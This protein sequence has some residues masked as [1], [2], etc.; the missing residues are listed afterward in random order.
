MK[1]M[2]SVILAFIFTFM[3]GGVSFGGKILEP[4][5]PPSKPPADVTGAYVKGYFTVAYDKAYP[6]K[7][8]HHNVHAVL[9]WDRTGAKNG[10]VKGI[11]KGKVG[12][13]DLK[14]LTKTAIPPQPKHLFSTTVYKPDNENLCKYNGEFLRGTYGHLPNELRVQEAF[15]VPDGK[16]YITKLEITDKDF[17]GDQPNAMIRGEVEILIYIPK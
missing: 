13:I 17:C 9:E 14:K 15:G 6:H 2:I 12:S 3:I 8:T 7:Y 16:C 1:K 11:E 4:P 5:P 10:M